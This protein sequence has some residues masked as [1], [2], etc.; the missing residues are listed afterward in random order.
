M[1]IF[2]EKKDILAFILCLV[3][4]ADTED[5]RMSGLPMRSL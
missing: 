3:Y 2:K 1:Y 5:A 4:V